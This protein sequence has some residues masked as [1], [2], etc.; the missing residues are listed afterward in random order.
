MAFPGRFQ[1]NPAISLTVVDTDYKKFAFVLTS[2]KFAEGDFNF[3][4]AYGRA[5]ELDKESKL[6]FCLALYNEGIPHTQTIFL[7][8]D[9]TCARLIK[10][11][12]FNVTESIWPTSPNS[13]SSFSLECS[14]ET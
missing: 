6:K 7:K 5:W 2:G 4:M 13:G 1:I 14:S 11:D 8:N 12:Y 10:Q 9:D 3:L